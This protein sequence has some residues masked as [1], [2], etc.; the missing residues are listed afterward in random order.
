MD[1]VKKI[2]SAKTGPRDRPVK[3]IVIESIAIETK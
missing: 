3:D 2:G 1:V